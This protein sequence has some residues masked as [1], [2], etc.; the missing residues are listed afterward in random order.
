MAK[1]VLTQ[2]L[3]PW[4]RPVPF[5]SERLDIVAAGWPLCLRTVAAVA[6]LVKDA[7]KLTLGQTLTIT[8]PHAIEGI[9]KQPPD[10]W[11]SN[12]RITHYQ[13]LLLNP[14]RILFQP[15]SSLNPATLL[16]D[17]DADPPLH[18]C[19]EILAQVHSFR[20][21]LTDV[22]LQNADHT[23]FT[24]GSS[25]IQD[26]NKKA[27]AAVTTK[28]KVIWA[29]PLPPVTSAQRAE[30][31]ALTKALILGKDLKVNIYMDSRY[32]FTMAHVHGAIYQ[33]RGLLT[34]EGKTIKN[35]QE[36]MDL[37]QALWIPEKGGH[38]PLP[39]TPER[40]PSRCQG[41]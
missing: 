33:E 26:G 32:A 9:L 13:A 27:G 36:I 3:G 21:D 41:K 7:N 37:L 17:L 6:S 28:D 19:T 16:P 24:D 31:I 34:S 38:Y 8:I 14:D 23:W 25:F 39:R 40:R 10:R 1:G 20:E 35:K 5:L 11:L 4:K 12:A 18:D 2:M 15:P 22:P 30:L 29:Q